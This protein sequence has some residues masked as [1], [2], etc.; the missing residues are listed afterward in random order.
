MSK[1]LAIGYK[2]DLELVY[3]LRFG[4]Y[5]ALCKLMF[6]DHER[7]HSKEGQEVSHGKKKP[8][9]IFFAISF[10]SLAGGE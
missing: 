5:Q 7:S 9:C 6:E 4:L 8:T 2:E 1:L 3:A 10:A